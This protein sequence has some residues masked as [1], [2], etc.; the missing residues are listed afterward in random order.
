MKMIISLS[1][2]LLLILPNAYADDSAYISYGNV[3]LK[4]A[5]SE[6]EVLSLL[7]RGGLIAK[8]YKDVKQAKEFT[9]YGVYFKSDDSYHGQ[10]IFVNDKLVHISKPWTPKI[11]SAKNILLSLYG[12]L[13]TILKDNEGLAVIKTSTF[14]QPDYEVKHID[15]HIGAY[16]VNISGILNYENT[17]EDRFHIIQ[18]LQSK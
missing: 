7:N 9:T 18:Y 17:Q 2:C 8:P 12:G 11:Q 15:L 6:R 5:M 4:L 1:I 14:T 13:T 16:R 10:I 3:N